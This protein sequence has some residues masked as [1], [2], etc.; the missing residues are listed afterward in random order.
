MLRFDVVA[1][2]HS[3]GGNRQPTKT[4]NEPEEQRRKAMR[5]DVGFII[6]ALLS[7]IF[8]ASVLSADTTGKPNI[9]FCL[10]DDQ[11]WFHTRANG[12]L[13]VKTPVFDRVAKQGALFT[14]AYCAAPS[15]TP[16]RS[17]ILTG[18]DIWRLGEGGQLFGTLPAKHPIYTDLLREN[19]YQVGFSDKGWA[20]GSVT[21]GG[22]KENGAGAV[23]GDFEGFLK[24]TSK[25]SPW[26]FWFGSRDPHR[27][28][29]KGSG[30]RAGLDPKKVTVPGFLPDTPEVR[31]DLCDYLCEIERF[32]RKIGEMLNILE[33]TG[34]LKNTIIVITSDN[35]MPFPR[36]KANLYDYG[37]R[38]PMAI[39]WLDKMP[40][41]RV[42]NDFVNQIDLAPTFLEAAGVAVPKQMSG[43]SLMPLIRSTKSDRIQQERNFVV[44]ARERHAWCRID[45]KGYPARMIRTHEYLYIRNYEPDRWPAGDFRVKTNEGAP[46]DIDGSPSKGYLLKNKDTYPNLYQLS[47]GK[48]PA[49]ELYECS[50]DPYQLKNLAA[51][52]AFQGL[53]KKLSERLS[54]HLKV[55]GDPRETG[56]KAAWDDF[57]YYG[58]S[59]WEIL[60]E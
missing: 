31:G 11:S 20:P 12:E 10:S 2:P 55:T 8:S 44:T 59:N 30:V 5:K 14:Q 52:P 1:L 6:V 45:G 37:T 27:P 50:K 26:C 60:P 58:R 41:G 34:Q 22:R 46:G 15:C 25:G 36:A 57:K 54:E 56:K 3:G 13:A 48:R 53:K 19:G 7:A 33:Q 4:V 49:E 38:M 24:K 40:G 9:L 21:A 42:I 39:C 51:N 29:E 16:S 35:G 28:Y 43:A 32:D 23:F 17:A 18:Q 47:F